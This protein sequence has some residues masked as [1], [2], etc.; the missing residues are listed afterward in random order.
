[1]PNYIAYK[2]QDCTYSSNVYSV[3]NFPI[4]YLL[5]ISKNNVNEG[6]MR[7]LSDFAWHGSVLRFSCFDIVGWKTVKN[8]WPIK[9][10]VPFILADS[11]P[12]LPS[13]L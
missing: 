10:P 12:D 9:N 3:P 8:I 11:L 2:K 4:L 1:M 7:P 5:H 13:V 6:K